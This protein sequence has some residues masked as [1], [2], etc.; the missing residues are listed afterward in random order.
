MVTDK[1]SGRPWNFTIMLEDL[2]F[3]DS[4]ALL[5]SKSNVF[6]KFTGTLTE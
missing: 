4:I 1:R 6:H 5:S 3:S 2:D